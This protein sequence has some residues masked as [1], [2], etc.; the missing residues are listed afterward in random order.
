MKAIILAAGYAT[1]LYPLTLNIPKPLLPIAEKPMI[2]YLL[3]SLKDFSDLDEIYI[4]TNNKFY[5]VFVEWLKDYEF[6]K[7]IKIINDN[8]NSNE[9]RLGAVGDINFVIEKE[10][11]NEDLIVL[12]GDNLFNFGLNKMYNLFKEKKSSVIAVYDLLDPLKLAN[13]FGTVL[14][15]DDKKVVNFEEKP[16]KPKSSLCA[17]VIYFITQKDL[18]ILNKF[19]TSKNRPDNIGEIIRFLVENSV[20]YAEPFKDGWID[21]GGKEEYDLANRLYLSNP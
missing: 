8:T 16:A 11:I 3:E 21:I 4:I 12:A 17:T 7:K 2:E 10:K 20:V 14:T 1:R 5:S 6:H 18:K 13:K 19:I 15:D 9:D